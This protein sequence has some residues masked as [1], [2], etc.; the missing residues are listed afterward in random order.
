MELMSGSRPRYMGLMS[1]SVSRGSVGVWLNVSSLLICMT[2]LTCRG[3][4]F[5]GM[6]L[7]AAQ[8]VAD[9]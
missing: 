7:S 5:S 9:L 4:L 3:S 2:R 8:V 1:L 6:F